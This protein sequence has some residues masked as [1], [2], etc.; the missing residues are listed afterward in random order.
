MRK[1]SKRIRKSNQRMYKMRGCS[2][3]RKNRTRTR[4]NK[5]TRT[6][7]HYLGGTSS[8]GADLNLAYPSN[9]VQTTKS[10]FLAYTGKG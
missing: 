9:N 10:P 1:T 2:K 6:R 7:N 4:T 3:S 5:R 8:M